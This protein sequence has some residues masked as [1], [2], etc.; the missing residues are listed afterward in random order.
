[1]VFYSA[2]F[3]LKGDIAHPADTAGGGGD[4]GMLVL[5]HPEQQDN[6]KLHISYYN[7]HF[8]IFILIKLASSTQT[9]FDQLEELGLFNKKLCGLFVK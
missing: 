5:G 6:F 4:E 3:H 7:S 1:M 8:I 9:E 2:Q